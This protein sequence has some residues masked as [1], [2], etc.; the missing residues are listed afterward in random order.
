MRL[1]NAD[2][3]MER[4]EEVINNLREQNQNIAEDEGI[5]VYMKKNDD[6]I[7]GLE[8]AKDIVEEMADEVGGD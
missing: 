8:W 3:A 6:K 7:F 2:K 4:I 5:C 1:I